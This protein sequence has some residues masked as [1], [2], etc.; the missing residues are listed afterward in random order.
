MPLSPPRECW[1]KLLAAVADHPTAEARPWRS[2]LLAGAWCWMGQDWAEGS[3]RDNR[4]W[5]LEKLGM[6]LEPSRRAP[7]VKERG[8]PFLQ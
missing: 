8:L 3:H 4:M 7:R 6:V 1:V 2:T 5:L